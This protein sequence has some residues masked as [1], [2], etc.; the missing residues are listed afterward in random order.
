MEGAN[1]SGYATKAGL[2]CSDGRTITPDAFKHMNG[3]TV[4]LVWQHMHKDVNSVLGHAVL[5]ARS[6]GMYAYGFFNETTQGENARLMVE[7]QD[8]KAM[9]IYANQ[10]REQSGSVLHG[11]IREVSLVL[12]GA[13][14][15]ATI[16][17][18]QI[19]HS[20][21]GIEEKDDE[22]I[23]HSG[24]P[25]D[26]VWVYED[27]LEHADDPTVQEVYDSFS[28]LEKN[29][30][31]YLIGVAMD[32]GNM[33]QSD[34]DE[35]DL[36][37][38]EGTVVTNLFEQGGTTKTGGELKHVFD[39]ADF[40][41]MVKEFGSSR[42][43]LKQYALKHSVGNMEILFPDFK[44]LT[45]TPE[46]NK[47]RTEWVA[48][49]LNGVGRTPFS[50][51]KTLIA[52]ITM[53][54]ARALGYIKGNFKKE[55]WFDLTQ[56]T[57]S[58]TTIY[59]KQKFDRDDLLDITEFD[60]VAWVKAEMRLMLEEEIARAILVGDGRDS[61]DVDKIKD[62]MAVTD[63]TGIRSIA[64]EHELFAPTVYVNLDDANSSYKELITTLIMERELYKGSGR[65]TLYTTQRTLS[66]MLLLEDTQ[67]R[68]LYNN[69]SDL[70]SVL[71]VENIVPVE[72]ME[73]QG[74]LVAIMVNLSD[75]NVGADRGGEINFF[76]DFDID[77]NQFK[78]LYETRVSG[79]LTKIRSA[80]IVRKTAAANVLVDP[81][82][83]PTFVKATGVVTIPTQTGVVYKNADTNATLTAGAQTALV[84]GATLK[85][86]AVPATNYYFGTNARDEWSYTRPAS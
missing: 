54:Q 24:V 27:D 4:P 13:N 72:V 80:L 38:Q 3:Q 64:N 14:P 26:S 8:I 25:I 51:I 77:Y 69:K 56:R 28:D 53:D 5:E 10:L 50:R 40:I 49:V 11:Q 44:A 18:V 6:D 45:A 32:N 79:A 29:V 61:G 31:H 55:E 82:T 21:G 71:D 2:K 36:A 22:V 17:N 73:N 42:E 57:T 78:Y 81:I 48:G 1:F 43:A 41:G 35:D 9:S 58:P 7:H 34:T 37:H 75:Y 83:V 86:K 74:D 15:G 62:P 20:D 46:F 19:K 66:R 52:D 68:R 60:F 16:D 47:R 23:I 63:G 65:P 12:S 39:T 33:Q 70:M 30:V 85:V 67:G 76:D 84:A 59:K